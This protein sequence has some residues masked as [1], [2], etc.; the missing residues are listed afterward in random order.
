MVSDGGHAVSKPRVAHPSLRWSDHNLV[1]RAQQGDRDAFGVLVH[2]YRQRVLNLATRYL[3]NHE[4]AEDA[5]QEIF[6]K[7]YCGLRTF[8]GE[9]AFYSWLHR[10]AI[11]SARTAIAQRARH[12][13]VVSTDAAGA[14]NDSG[15]LLGTDLDLPEALALTAEIC[16]TVAAAMECLCGELRSTIVMREIEGLS[17]KQI[18]IAMSCPVGTVRSRVFRAREAIDQQLRDLC[19]HGLGRTRRTRGLM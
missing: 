19:E 8:R 1:A 6:L 16:S 9:S 5:A 13:S 2:K 18:A 15:A 11:N 4:D 7:A 3:R 10:I 17:Y 12:S 14:A